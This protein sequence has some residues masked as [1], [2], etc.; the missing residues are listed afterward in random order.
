MHGI[1]WIFEHP[2]H[3]VTQEDGS[4][5]LK[6]LPSDVELNFKAWHETQIRP[7]EQRKLTL[8]KGEPVVIDL[9][10]K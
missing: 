2:Y 3:T 6:D 9:K 1:V 5:E 7:F 10:I 8:K 4:F